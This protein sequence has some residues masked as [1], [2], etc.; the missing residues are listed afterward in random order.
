MFAGWVGDQDSSSDGLKKAMYNILKS[1][2]NGYLNFGFDIGGYRGQKIS[3]NIYIRWVQV[4]SLLPFMENGG[5]GKHQP[6]L[7]DQE[8]VDIYRSFV[9]LHYKLKPTF[10]SCANEKYFQK[11]SVITPLAKK[12]GQDSTKLPTNYCY[13][14][15]DNMLVC[16]IFEENGQAEVVFP[17]NSSWIYYFD[18]N[19]YFKGGTH[20]YLTFPINETPLFLKSNS[21]VVM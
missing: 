18:H 14:L 6:W 19:K 20:S 2:W 16:P 17:S 4:G 8:I 12:I 9:D 15:C 11:K 21:V 1:A 7:F 5:N 3:K 10:L 13:L